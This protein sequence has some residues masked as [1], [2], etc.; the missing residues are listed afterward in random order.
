MVPPADHLVAVV[1]AGGTSRRF[2][3]DKLAADVRGRPLLDNALDGL[4]DSAAIAV[5]G[6]PRP[7]DRAATFL[8][9]EPP[10]GG[11]AA[12][13]ITGLVWALAAGAGAIVTLPGDAPGG[14]RAAMMLLA[15]LDLR[16]QDALV[17]VDASGREQV[18]QLALRPPAAELLIR[19][20][21][22]GR[23]QHQSVRRLV[24][25]LVHGQLTL[26]DD[27]SADID[28]TEQLRQFRNLDRA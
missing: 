25:A 5:V 10:G 12:G 20:A 13:L 23:G 18:L 17:G 27:L 15:E 6:P 26:P 4:P 11:P 21:G 14:G 7:L 9:E 24:T 19:H 3:G 1:L 28:T 2:G 22:P 16:G 8:R